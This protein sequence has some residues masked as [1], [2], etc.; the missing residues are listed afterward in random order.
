MIPAAYRLKLE[1]KQPFRGRR[2]PFSSGTIV[3]ANSDHLCW[4]ITISKKSLPKATARNQL[5]R[6]INHHLYQHKNRL[7]PNSAFKIIINRP[8]KEHPAL[9]QELCSLLFIAI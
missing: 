9:I 2:H 6:Q 1:N 7:S 4:S 8:P 5:R 3:V